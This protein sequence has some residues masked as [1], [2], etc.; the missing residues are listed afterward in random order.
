MKQ[1][2][3]C[4]YGYGVCDYPIEDCRNCPARPENQRRNW[5]ANHGKC[6]HMNYEFC[7]DCPYEDTEKCDEVME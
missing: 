6:S 1:P 5:E 4:I 7:D 2:E 3:R